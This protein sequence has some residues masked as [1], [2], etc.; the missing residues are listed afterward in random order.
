MLFVSR[1]LV[2]LEKSGFELVSVSE[3]DLLK[4]DPTRTFCTACFVAGRLASGLFATAQARALSLSDR[5]SVV[6]DVTLQLRLA[7]SDVV[8]ILG[9]FKPMRLASFAVEA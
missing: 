5:L 8:V 7:R 6:V 3:P 1:D 4:D 2:L 9:V